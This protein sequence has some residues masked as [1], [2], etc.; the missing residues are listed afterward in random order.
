MRGLSLGP[1]VVVELRR[2]VL[3]VAAF[4]SDAAGQDGGHVVAKVIPL[5]LLAL[6]L[7]LTQV[8]TLS[9]GLQQVTAS[10]SRGLGLRFGS[11]ARC[12]ATT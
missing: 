7:H 1:V 3:A 8:K 2:V 6:R 4:D 9:D 11:G 12:S 5:F 10:V